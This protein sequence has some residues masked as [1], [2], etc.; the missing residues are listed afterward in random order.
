MAEQADW[1]DYGLTYFQQAGVD[2][3]FGFGLRSAIL[4]FDKKA[5]IRAADTILAKCP[6]DKSQL[7][8]LENHDLDRFASLE[9]DIR[10]QKAAAALMGPHRWYSFYLLRAGDWHAAKSVS[11]GNTDGNDIPRREAFEWYKKNEGPAIAFWYKNTGEWW[12][13]SNSNT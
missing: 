8:F 6:D 1:N 2:R 5:L 4:S 9:P 10:K 11:L 7:I 12:N 13:K 3:M